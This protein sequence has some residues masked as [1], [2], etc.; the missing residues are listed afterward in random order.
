MSQ[1]FYN[2]LDQ[3]LKIEEDIKKVN[4]IIELNIDKIIELYKG[5]I[6]IKRA[7][8]NRKNK[9]KYDDLSLRVFELKIDIS[10]YKNDRIMLK[11]RLI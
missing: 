2:L 1:I 4:K 10:H 3:K 9:K 6:T 11:D 5:L 7:I 8:R